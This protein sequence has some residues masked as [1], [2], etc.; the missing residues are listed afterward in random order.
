M[1]KR[2]L[3]FAVCG[4]VLAPLVLG[5]CTDLKRAL[6]MEKVVP[7]E[8][9]V[10]R[11]APLALPPDFSLRPPRPG[12]A[13]TQEISPTEQA[14]QTIFKASDQ[15]TAT[16]PDADKLSAGENQLL[17]QAGAAAAPRDIRDTVNREA[18]QSP[19]PVDESFAD[20]L[21]F[22]RTPEKKLGPTDAVIDPAQEAQRLKAS[23]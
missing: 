3:G 13:P 21:L 8:F 10:V 9:A 5:G 16:L 2:S 20:K 1:P 6:G 17:R 22:W 12:A 15:Q 11:S 23:P 7:D 4:L 18:M 14:R 19:A